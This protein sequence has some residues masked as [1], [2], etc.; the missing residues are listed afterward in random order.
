MID[1]MDKNQDI[2]T[3]F[4]NEQD[5]KKVLSELLAKRLYD[6]IRDAG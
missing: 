3:K 2:V 5:F 4:L 6:E 1:R